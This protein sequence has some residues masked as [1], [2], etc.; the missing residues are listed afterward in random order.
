MAIGELIAVWPK[1]PEIMVFDMNLDC[2]LCPNYL[3]ATVETKWAI[4]WSTP[5]EEQVPNRAGCD[6]NRAKDCIFGITYVGGMILY[7]VVEETR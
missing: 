2:V 7:T 4:S 1:N 3:E 6:V 5:P